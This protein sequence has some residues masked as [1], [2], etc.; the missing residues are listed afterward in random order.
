MHA[1]A[2]AGDARCDGG[3]TAS[4]GAR[5]G[6]DPVGVP[7]V[8]AG[9]VEKSSRWVAPEGRARGVSRAAGASAA[10]ASAGASASASAASFV[11]APLAA[12]AASAASAARAF[13]SSSSGGAAYSHDSSKRGS[14]TSS[15]SDHAGASSASGAG[16]SQRSPS[17]STGGAKCA[18]G[19][20]ASSVS[21]SRARRAAS[22][23]SRARA[24][25]PPRTAFPPVSRGGGNPCAALMA[26]M[27]ATAMRPCGTWNTGVALRWN[28]AERSTSMAF[29]APGGCA[30]AASRLVSTMLSGASHARTL[31]ANGSFLLDP[32]LDPIPARPLRVFSAVIAFSAFSRASRRRTS[33][34]D[35]PSA[36]NSTRGSWPGGSIRGQ[37]LQKSKTRAGSLRLLS[38]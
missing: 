6:E 21:A 26:R 11:P 5:A 33:S 7:C 15:S 13:C 38:M 31:N 18:S 30:Y 25:A 1:L 35:G 4:R 23:A 3:G 20:F 12:S 19:G 29:T 34:G 10:G 37:S 24:T 2:G 17:H 14:Q 27:S 28:G 8:A 9:C 36:E 22:S 32:M 16:G